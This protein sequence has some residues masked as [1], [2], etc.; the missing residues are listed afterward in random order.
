MLNTVMETPSQLKRIHDANG[1]DINY[2]M[3]EKRY[4]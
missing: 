2:Y 4:R 1:F 3:P